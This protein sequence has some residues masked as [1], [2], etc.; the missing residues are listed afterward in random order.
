MQSKNL[1]EAGAFPL[2]PAKLAGG[3]IITPPG[4]GAPGP[5]APNGLF[6]ILP[7]LNAAA[8]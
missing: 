7:A 2:A 3:G 5:P 6:W 8:I 4:P 1:L